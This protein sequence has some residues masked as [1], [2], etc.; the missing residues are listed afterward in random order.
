[1]TLIPFSRADRFSCQLA[2]GE[3]GEVDGQLV[4]EARFMH[5][6]Y[7]GGVTAEFLGRPG[8]LKPGTGR[9]RLQG[10]HVDTGAF[11]LDG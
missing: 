3:G 10:I 8:I 11:E 5:L 1:M 6:P 9:P 4:D 2:G 7:F